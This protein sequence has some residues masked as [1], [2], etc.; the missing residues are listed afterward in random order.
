L[1]KELFELASFAQARGWS[2][3][4]LLSAETKK[5]EWEL[6]RRERIQ[7]RFKQAKV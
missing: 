4:E 1:A 2:G 3:E 5:R 7:A 6:R